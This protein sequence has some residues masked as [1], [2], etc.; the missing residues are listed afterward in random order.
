MPLPLIRYPLDTTGLNTDNYVNGEIHNL[1][2]KPVRAIAPTYGAY[3]TESLKV[4]DNRTQHMLVRGT[5]YICTELLQ[6]PT[7]MYGKEICYLILIIDPNVSSEV[8]IQYQVLGGLYTNSGDAIINIYETI[9]QDNRPINWVD[10]LN[11]PLG[12]TP[13]QHLHDGRDIY[14]FEYLVTSLE[15]IRNAIVASDVPVYEGIMDWLSTELETIRNQTSFPKIATT[16]EAL[17]GVVDDK[18]MTPLK[19]K[20]VLDKFVTNRAKN[21]FLAQL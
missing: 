16:Q 8:I 20:E 17:A 19:V 12:Y 21:Y 9:M 2:N 10:V 14:G 1:S 15:R 7:E 18:L 5:Q 6:T 11:K 3:F 4:F 13:T